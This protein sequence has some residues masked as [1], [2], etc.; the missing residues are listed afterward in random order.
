VPVIIIFKW[1]FKLFGANLKRLRDQNDLSKKRFIIQSIVAY[2][3]ALLWVLLVFWTY[4]KWP[5]LS[6]GTKILLEIVDNLT[7][8]LGISDFFSYKTWKERREKEM[9][10]L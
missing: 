7:V 6:L 3:I 1:L 10:H 2:F 4:I 8:P 9:L 5:S